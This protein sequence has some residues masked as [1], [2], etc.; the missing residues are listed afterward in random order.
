MNV[1]D[2]F[3]ALQAAYDEGAPADE[4]LEEVEAPKVPNFDRQLWDGGNR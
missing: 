1:T 2:E 3:L 4:V